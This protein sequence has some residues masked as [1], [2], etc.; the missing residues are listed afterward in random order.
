MRSL[1]F[2][3]VMQRRLVVSYRRFGQP[4]G[5]PSSRVRRSTIL[6]SLVIFTRFFFQNQNMSHLRRHFIF[7]KTI[8]TQQIP[9]K[10]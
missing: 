6:L 1:L 8:C 2:W 4:I 5:H 7:L 3:G 10:I 9:V